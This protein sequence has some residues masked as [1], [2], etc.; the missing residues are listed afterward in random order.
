QLLRERVKPRSSA[1]A[2]QLAPDGLMF[3]VKCA[4]RRIRVYDVATGIACGGAIPVGEGPGNELAF[5]IGNDGAALL[6]QDS[7]LQTARLWHRGRVW[8]L[9]AAES[10]SSPVVP[11]SGLIFSLVSFSPD[12]RTAFLGQE[13]GQYGRLVEVAS[14]SPLGMP[15]RVAG[16]VPER[17]LDAAFSAD[18]ALVATS[19]PLRWDVEPSVRVW[20]AQSGRPRTP[21]MRQRSFIHAFAFS[22]DGQTL[23]AGAVGPTYLWDVAPGPPR[24]RL[25][26]PGPVWQL[27][28]RADGRRLAAATRWGWNTPSGAAVQPGFQ[29]WDPSNGQPI[30]AYAP[31]AEAPFMTYLPDGKTLQ[32]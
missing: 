31:M 8:R 11:S 6:V 3:A 29:L 32:T 25:A 28:F 7:W 4:D 15:L 20:D 17:S 1:Y 13:D 30:G 24:A 12:R 10:S 18:S 14:S 2:A 5:A 27:A 21:W 23:A 16:R 26:Q 22:P 9:G 19:T